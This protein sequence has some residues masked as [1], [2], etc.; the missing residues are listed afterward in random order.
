MLC[1]DIN[2][3]C[4]HHFTRTWVRR[5]VRRR[6]GQNHSSL[7]KSIVLWQIFSVPLSHLSITWRSIICCVTEVHLAIGIS[8]PVWVHLTPFPWN[9]KGWHQRHKMANALCFTNMSF[10]HPSDGKYGRTSPNYNH[11]NYLKHSPDMVSSY[12]LSGVISVWTFPCVL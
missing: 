4:L 6:A 10:N 1:Y 3:R 2:L 8:K 7:P 9:L 12:L 11:A 5:W